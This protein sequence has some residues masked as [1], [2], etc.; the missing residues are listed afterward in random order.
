MISCDIFLDAIPSKA[1]ADALLRADS[2]P[3]FKMMGLDARDMMGLPS[4]APSKPALP[5]APKLKG[6][7]PG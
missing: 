3:W 7:G 5:K 2:N 1:I 4:A 6:R